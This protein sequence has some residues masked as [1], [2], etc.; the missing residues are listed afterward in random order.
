MHLAE[1]WFANPS[2]GAA[3]LTLWFP[4]FAAALA[5]LGNLLNL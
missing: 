1:P 5:S 3:V 4:F 2:Y